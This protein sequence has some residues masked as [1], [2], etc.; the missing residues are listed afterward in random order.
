MY[1]SLKSWVDLPITYLAYVSVDGTGDTVYKEPVDIL[2]Y[3]V[4]KIK[5]V[6]DFKGQEVL[7]TSH[8]YLPGDFVVNPLDKFIFEDTERTIKSIETFYRAGKADIRVVYM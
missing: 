2:C 7:S 8:I 1:A 5:T 6:V 4:K 3:A